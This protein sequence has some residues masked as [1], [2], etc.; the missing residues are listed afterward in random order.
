MKRENIEL[1]LSTHGW[2]RDN[3]G[4]FKKD[5]GSNLYRCK[6]QATSLRVERKTGDTWFKITSDYYKNVR[7]ADSDGSLVVGRKALAVQ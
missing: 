7:I 5:N 4:H 6:M 1:W 3:W 2:A